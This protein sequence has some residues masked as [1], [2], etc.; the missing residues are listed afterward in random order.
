MVVVDEDVTHDLEHPTL[1]VDVVDELIIVVEHT[2]RCAYKSVTCTCSYQDNSGRKDAR[3][4]LAVLT[5][6]N[7]DQKKRL[8][9]AL[10]NIKTDYLPK[11]IS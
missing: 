9:E 11:V 3:R 10:Q 5:E 7:A 2:Q 1:E 4:R 6:N 8:F